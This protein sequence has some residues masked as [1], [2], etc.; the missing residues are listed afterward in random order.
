MR[1]QNFLGE[2][3]SAIKL[4]TRATTRTVVRHEEKLVKRLHDSKRARLTPLAGLVP[5]LASQ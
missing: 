4:R 5:W 2:F 3:I 1:R